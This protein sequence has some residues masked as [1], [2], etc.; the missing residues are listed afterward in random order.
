MENSQQMQVIILDMLIFHFYKKQSLL[1]SIKFLKKWFWI[2]Q[3]SLL[4]V[5]YFWGIIWFNKRKI[6]VNLFTLFVFQS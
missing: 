1:V 2:Y 4:M 6:Q 3:K 5:S